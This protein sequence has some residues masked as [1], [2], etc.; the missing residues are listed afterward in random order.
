MGQ[1]RVPEV[2]F[3]KMFERL[4]PKDTAV[5]LQTSVREVYRRRARIEARIGRQLTA[6]GSTT[7]S[8]IEHA[9]RRHLNV[10]DGVVLI[11]SDAHYWPGIITP[12]HRAFVHFAKTLKPAAIIMNGDVFDGAS[13]SRHPS[14]GWEDKPSVIDEIDACADR[15]GEIEKA[16]PKA[17]KFW[18]LGNHDARFE[19]RLANVAPEYARVHG[20]QLKDHFPYW[21]PCWSVWVNDDVVVKHRWKGGIHAVHG[22]TVNSGKSFVTG[23][24]HSLKVAPWTD[25]N[26]TRFGVDTGTLAAPYGPQFLDYTEDNPVAW[27]SGFAVLTFKNGRLIWPEVVHVI[28][29]DMV[30]FRGDTISV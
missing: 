3:I 19:S 9:A 11:A 24:L 26:G 4:G 17:E 16:A 25:Y 23:H 29:D 30:E 10:R 27:R 8:N 6:P 13:V 5:R 28:G 12:A 22:N 20:V 21:K 1:P 7:R 18:T 2:E 14:I 15:L